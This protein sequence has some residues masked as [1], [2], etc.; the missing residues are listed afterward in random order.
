MGRG[1][2]QR[3][4]GCN[5]GT[6]KKSCN[7]SSVNTFPPNLKLWVS[8]RVVYRFFTPPLAG[9][10]KLLAL[11]GRYFGI[12]ITILPKSHYWVFFMY[13]LAGTPFEDFAGTL[14]LKIWREFLLS[15]KRRA[16]C[17]KG[18]RSPPPSF[19]KRGLPPILKYQKY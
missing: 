8:T 2:F 9:I 4:V 19:G 5:F 14:F 15:L 7:F 10:G 16:K 6:L 11:F 18:G 17:T 12:G 1:R 13:D 3:W